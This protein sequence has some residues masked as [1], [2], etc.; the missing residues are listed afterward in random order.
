MLI[1]EAEYREMQ[2]EIKRLK[3]LLAA[4]PMLLREQVFDSDEQ[5]QQALDLLKECEKFNPALP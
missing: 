5:Y 4:V 2:D 3:A 1:L